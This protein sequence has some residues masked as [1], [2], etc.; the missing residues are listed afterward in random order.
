MGRNRTKAP[1]GLWI[2]TRWRR[3]RDWLTTSYRRSIAT[4]GIFP[5]LRARD[6]GMYLSLRIIRAFGLFMAL[7]ARDESEQPGPGSRTTCSDPFGAA[8]RSRHYQSCLVK[9]GPSPVNGVE[10]PRVAVCRTE[11]SNQVLSL[12]HKQM[13][14]RLG[15]LSFMAESEG[16]ET[17]Q[18]ESDAAECPSMPSKSKA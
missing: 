12:F 18:G 13:G 16:F 7:R 3:A 9:T 8:R 14:P 2:E 17:S 11:G 15:P 4:V 10:P 6:W 1:W 5:T